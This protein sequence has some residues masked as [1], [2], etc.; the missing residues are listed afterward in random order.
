M[1]HFLRNIKE[2]IHFIPDT[3]IL[4]NHHVIISHM[5]FW[6]NRK[7]TIPLYNRTVILIPT[8]II[9][10]LFRI[11]KDAESLSIYQSKCLAKNVNKQFIIFHNY[12]K[13]CGGLLL[14]LIHLV[15]LCF[16]NRFRNNE[17]SFKLVNL[18]F[19]LSFFKYKKSLLL[20]FF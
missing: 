2:C 15:F 14:Y 1:Q 20:T 13:I 4:N 8:K 12:F 9:L 5:M 6:F 17:G 10:S 18:E 11:P 7:K 16:K 3:L 19:L